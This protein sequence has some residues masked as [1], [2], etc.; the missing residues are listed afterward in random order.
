ML[1]SRKQGAGETA[2]W[3]RALVDLLEVLSPIPSTHMVAHTCNGMWHPLLALRSQNQPDLCVFQASCS[4]Q[5][6]KLSELHGDAL[7][8]F[9]RKEW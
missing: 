6:P 9:L 2:Q 3:L 5:V 1:K 7:S 8:L 4:P